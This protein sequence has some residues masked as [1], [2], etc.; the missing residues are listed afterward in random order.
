MTCG[1][2]INC[3]SFSHLLC[4]CVGELGRGRQ[5][6]VKVTARALTMETRR[7]QVEKG[8]VAVKD[9]ACAVLSGWRGAL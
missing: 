1:S 9:D 2:A 8:D 7:V 5:S 3:V 6:I 4:L